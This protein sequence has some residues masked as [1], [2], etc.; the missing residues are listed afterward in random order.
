ML[1]CGGK[2]GKFPVR[3]GGQVIQGSGAEH[4]STVR[5]SKCTTNMCLARVCRG[6]ACFFVVKKLL[7]EVLLNESA[8]GLI[9]QSIVK[10]VRRL[11]TTHLRQAGV[12]IGPFLSLISLI[13]SPK[14]SLRL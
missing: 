11:Q 13:F 4:A 12:Y 10:V 9:I 5:V 2:G 8:K 3:G 14:T 6:T 1:D 7:T